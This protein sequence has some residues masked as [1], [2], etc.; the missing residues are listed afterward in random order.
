M[1][2]SKK[3]KKV[4]RGQHRHGPL[5]HPGRIGGRLKVAVQDDKTA[6]TAEGGHEDAFGPGVKYVPFA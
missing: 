3:K 5:Q 2:K 4:Y 1:R 6:Q